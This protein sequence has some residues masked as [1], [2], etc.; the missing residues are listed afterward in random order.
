MARR[1]SF[2]H[3]AGVHL[4]RISLILALFYLLS[5]KQITVGQF[6]SLYL[7]SFF[8][9]GP[10]QEFGGVVRQYREMEVSLDKFRVFMAGALEPRT[11]G[12]PALRELTSLQFRDVTFRYRTAHQAA[13]AG[14]SFDVERGETI[15][16]VGPSG[17]GKSTLVKLIAGLYVPT[18][19]QILYNDTA[20]GRVDLEQ[21]RERIGM[22]TQ[23]TQ[24][25]S[26]TIRQNLRFV[27]PEATDEDCLGALRQAAAGA[28]L[29]RAPNGLDSLIGEGGLR[30]SGG[31]RQR[32]AIARALLR[33]PD[34]LVFDEA[35]SS[36]DSL[37]EEEIGVAIRLAT[38]GAS[39]MT[40]LIAHRLST[41]L[42][43]DRIYVL[44]CG[45][46]VQ[47]GRHAELVEVPGLYRSIWLQQVGGE[48]LR[49]T[50]EI[51]E[52]AI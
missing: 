51:V 23:D 25:F 31:E 5:T 10:M 45:R 7:Y 46:V 9:F 8:I 39:V 28:M 48:S 11:S 32:L 1:F 30:L 27:C 35:T 24:L 14:V 6:F 43:A 42:D 15:A 44:D 19:G 22:V 40:I 50:A 37:T 12:A 26:G 52:K 33:H 3:G 18:G 47:T 16:F 13:I 34:L 49:E 17:A 36:L 21:V 4:L 41:V 29:A 2:L 38:V 20:S